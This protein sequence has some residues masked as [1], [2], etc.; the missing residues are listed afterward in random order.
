VKTHDVQKQPV[1]Q[2]GAEHAAQRG[3]FGA[4]LQVV[5]T[6]GGVAVALDD[7]ADVVVQR[8]HGDVALGRLGRPAQ[9][10]HFRRLVNG[11]VVALQLGHLVAQLVV[12]GLH[13]RADAVF[14]DLQRLF[15][16]RADVARRVT[17]VFGVPLVINQARQVAAKR[18][19]CQ[20]LVVGPGVGL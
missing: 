3:L 4:V 20:Q 13:H 11:K 1:V 9:R 6:D 7:F 19:P 17:V 2:L 10:R 16:H 15:H 5:V 14:V 18:Q 12:V 8:G